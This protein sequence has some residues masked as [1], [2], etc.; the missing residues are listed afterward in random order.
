VSVD[1]AED[2]RSPA[3][4]KHV[5]VPVIACCGAANQVS[6]LLQIPNRGAEE[7]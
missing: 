2:M 7:E 5:A 6:D 3:P 1:I 4:V